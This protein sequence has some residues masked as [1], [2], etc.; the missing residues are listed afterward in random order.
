MNGLLILKIL[1]LLRQKAGDT[2]RK[3]LFYLLIFGLDIQ[4]SIRDK[5]TWSKSMV[6]EWRPEDYCSKHSDSP[7]TTWDRLGGAWW[8]KLRYFKLSRDL[9]K[10]DI[11][12]SYQ[13]GKGT[14]AV[15]CR[16]SIGGSQYLTPVLLA[17]NLF[18]K[19][20]DKTK[21][22]ILQQSSLQLSTSKV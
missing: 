11:L 3:I 20:T 5:D 8:T 21:Q 6:L 13:R 2:G 18:C 19:C 10:G 17:M 1:G 15:K 16:N 4:R 14:E 9:C 12:F 22:D 7:H